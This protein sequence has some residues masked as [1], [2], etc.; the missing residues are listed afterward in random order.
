M[1]N[2]NLVRVQRKGARGHHLID[3]AKYEANPKA[4]VLCDDNGKPIGAA[5]AS[6]EPKSPAEPKAPSELGVLRKQYKEKFGKGASPK[7]DADAIRA[8]LAE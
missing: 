1:S 7:M 2:P 5:K 6:G 3:R 8:K 4:Y